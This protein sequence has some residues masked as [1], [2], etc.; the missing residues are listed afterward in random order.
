LAELDVDRLEQRLR[1]AGL[2]EAAISGMKDRLDEARTGRITGEAYGWD[3][4][5]G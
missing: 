1:A 2:S 4:R 5:A 3:L